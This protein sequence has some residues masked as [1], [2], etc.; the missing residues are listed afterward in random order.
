MTEEERHCEDVAHELLN[1]WPETREDMYRYVTST[2]LHER[3]AL[4][5]ERDEWRLAAGVE[6]GE[7]RKA[8]ERVA[9]LERSLAAAQRR[10]DEWHRAWLWEKHPE[11][12]AR[13]DPLSSLPSV[14]EGPHTKEK[15]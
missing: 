15:P 7:R 3:A 8:H 10:G 12:A 6:A 5:A 1:P 11:E 4:R 9:T 14:S 13:L 2:L